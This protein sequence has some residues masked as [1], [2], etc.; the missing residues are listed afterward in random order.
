MKTYRRAP[1]LSRLFLVSAALVP[2]LAGAQAVKMVSS[3]AQATS[4]AN[5]EVVRDGQQTLV[6]VEG[7]GPLRYH[8]TRQSDPLRVVI[9]FDGAR[10]AAPRHAVP[11]SFEPVRGL[12]LGQ[13]QPDQA[14][15]VVDLS[16]PALPLIDQ[17]GKFLFVSFADSASA[18]IPSAPAAKPA[19]L[20]TTDGEFAR[21]ELPLPRSLTSRNAGMA[22]PRQT[23]AAAAVVAGGQAVPGAPRA[24]PQDVVAQG[25]QPAPGQQRFTGEPISVN[26]KDVDLKD[27]FRLIHE[28]SG[29]NV[30]LDPSVGGTVTLVLDEVPWDQALDIVLRNNGLAKE[31]DGNVLRI[32]TEGTLRK[33]AED[34]SALQ[35]AQEQAV[36]PVTSTRVLSYAKASDM[37][38]PLRRFLS[39]R[40]DILSQDRANMLIIRDI[41]SVMPQ[42][43]NLI[44]QM[45]RK[46]QQVEIEA[47]VVQASRTFARDIGTQFG[48][49]GGWNGANSANVIGGDPI[50][51]PSP[52]VHPTAFPPPLVSSGAT[53][54]IPL[55]DR[56]SVV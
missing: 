14:R 21:K 54:S 34:H 56:K 43:D 10:L 39:P 16:R 25:G 24:V 53:G 44:R 49:A 32:V 23:A 52:L 26:L 42:I 9:D 27:F 11:S 30:V 20:S 6:R 48:V 36:E 22:S 2:L 1:R 12:R 4:V 18:R 40:G 50:A 38:V 55:L 17:S 45:D 8:I 33:E 46:T 28:I 41:P 7:S 19:K 5:V 29:L 51:N 37:V 31:I 3:P 13:F 35:K 15:L 47:R